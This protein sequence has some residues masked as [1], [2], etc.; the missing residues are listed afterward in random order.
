MPL[1]L[2]VP[3]RG[4]KSGA[5]AGKS[6]LWGVGTRCA[7]RTRPAIY[8]SLPLLA[9]P[10]GGG[11]CAILCQSVPCHTPRRN[12]ESR[13]GSRRSMASARA[14]TRPPVVANQPG[15][16][17]GQ[18]WR[19]SVTP[20]QSRGIFLAIRN[21]FWYYRHRATRSLFLCPTKARAVSYDTDDK[22]G[23]HVDRK[24]AA[25]GNRG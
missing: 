9:G 5:V 16:A 12:R 15:P 1:A 19:P 18:R 23:L 3:G 13:V 8:T 4:L 2:R 20:R 21:V 24:S 22:G 6:K 17:H 7:T 14:R 25:W 10:I 11:K